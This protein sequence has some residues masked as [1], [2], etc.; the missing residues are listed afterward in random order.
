MIPKYQMYTWSIVK[1]KAKLIDIELLDKL[2]VNAKKVGSIN[3]W[4][5]KIYDGTWSKIC[6]FNSGV[7]FGTKKIKAVEK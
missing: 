2:P 7:S 6:L 5:A 3:V 4:E 1:G